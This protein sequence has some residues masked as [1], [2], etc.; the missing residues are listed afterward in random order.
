MDLAA[1]TT[2]ERDGGAGLLLAQ[3]APLVRPVVHAY[4]F[5]RQFGSSRP[6]VFQSAFSR[7]IMFLY[8]RR[9]RR[10]AAAVAGHRTNRRR[11]AL[12]RYLKRRSLFLLGAA[13]VRRSP[14]H[15]GG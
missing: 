15:M 8:A 3:G 5:R 13:G 12:F 11:C 14:A 6:A 4:R 2:V 10:A 9:M 7:S 1:V